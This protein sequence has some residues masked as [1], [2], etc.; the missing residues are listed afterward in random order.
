MKTTLERAENAQF[1]R[2]PNGYHQLVKRW[3]ERCLLVETATPEDKEKVAL[4]AT[5][6]LIYAILR[7]RDYTKGFAFSEE[8]KF[9]APIIGKRAIPITAIKIVELIQNLAKRRSSS[10]T[11]TWWVQD[12]M[13]QIFEPFGDLLVPDVLEK[14][15]A[16]LPEAPWSA[17]SPYVEAVEA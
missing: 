4:N 11:N 2:D 9:T 15:A 8:E 6:Y 14:I 5:H 16:H 7:G 3:S 1:F 10:L 13:R 12:R 17:P